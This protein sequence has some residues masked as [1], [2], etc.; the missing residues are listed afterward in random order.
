[1]VAM[2]TT[3]FAQLA[4]MVAWCGALGVVTAGLTVVALRV[5]RFDEVPRHVQRRVRWWSAH[6]AA[7]LLASAAATGAGLIGLA[8]S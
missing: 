5:V 7:F 6:N 4:W 1:M 3:T 8:V 2:A